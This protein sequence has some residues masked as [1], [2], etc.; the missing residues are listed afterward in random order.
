MN[1][2]VYF[3]QWQL[4]DNLRERGIDVLTSEADG[5]SMRLLVDVHADA[6][7]LVENFLG[8]NVTLKVGSG[9]NDSEGASIMVCRSWLVDLFTFQLAQEYPL[10]LHIEGP[11]D[12]GLDH[13]RGWRCFNSLEDFID[14]RNDHQDV[15]NE[16]FWRVYECSGTALGGTRNRHEISGRVQ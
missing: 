11:R 5:L 1:T 12:P 10:V 2:G 16:L 14:F 6:I 8:G 15:L 9:W 3:N 13:W 4:F 7:P